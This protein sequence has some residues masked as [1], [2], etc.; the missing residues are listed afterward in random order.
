MTSESKVMTTDLLY[1]P[2]LA[3][4]VAISGADKVHVHA[5]AKLSRQSYV[6]KAEILL[7]NKRET[8]IVP[9]H[10]LR[11]KLALKDVKIDYHQKWLN[12]HLR[13]IKSAYGKSPFFEYFYDDL[14]QIYLRKPNFLIDLNL[15]LLTLC[16]KFLRWNVS[17][18]VK[19]KEEEGDQKNDLR[20]IIHPKLLTSSDLVYKPY[21]YMQIFGPNFV[22]NLSIVDLLFCEG[23]VANEVLN[24]SRK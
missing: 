19:E 14:E 23:P 7:T 6:N 13:G 21:P 1:L 8:L 20:G 22:S 5:D 9:V 4:F 18:V 17:L 11:K 10:G 3:Y 2:P 16:L 15:D 12:V 24:L